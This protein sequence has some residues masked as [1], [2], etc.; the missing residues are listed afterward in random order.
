MEKLGFWELMHGTSAGC[1]SIAV[2]EGMRHFAHGP[3]MLG[4]Y[5]A[6]TVGFFKLQQWHLHKLAKAQKVGFEVS[7]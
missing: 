2:F 3:V 6:I 5:G 7:K 1:A 4:V